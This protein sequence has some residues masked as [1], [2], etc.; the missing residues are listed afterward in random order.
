MNH[1][2]INNCFDRS[3]RQIYYKE[4]N[5]LWYFI[6]HFSNN[7]VAKSVGVFIREYIDIYTVNE[8]QKHHLTAIWFRVRRNL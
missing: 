6:C 2:D 4:Y 3:S 8:Q 5:L 1:V 7:L